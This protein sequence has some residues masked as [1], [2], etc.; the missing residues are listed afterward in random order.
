MQSAEY[1]KLNFY[2]GLTIVVFLG[3]LLLAFAQDAYAQ[4][5]S[6]KPGRAPSSRFMD[7]RYRHDHAYPARGHSISRLPRGYHPV[8][9]RSSRY[10]F[11][12]GVWYRPYGSYFTVVAPPFGLIVPF[13]PLYYSTIWVGGAPYFYANQVYYTR[14][15]GG[16]MVV[17]PPKENIVEAPVPEERLFIYPREGQSEKKQSDDRYECHRWAVDQT[18]YDPTQPPDSVPTSQLYQKRAD[19]QLAI[20]ACL[21]AR[22]Y[23]VK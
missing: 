6:S 23:T 14:T 8:V 9:H 17:E 4:R 3:A 10:Y 19:Y 22:G 7:S 20:S 12:G 2:I 1:K 16:Y 15:T 5:P 21:D 11:H 13:L 18:N